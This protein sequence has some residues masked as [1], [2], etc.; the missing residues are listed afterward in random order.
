MTS[1]THHVSA[2][3]PGSR[4][5]ET[6]RL[7]GAILGGLVAAVLIVTGVAAGQPESRSQVSLQ[8][9]ADAIVA[10]GAPGVVLLTRS[11]NHTV[12]ITS[13]LGEIST[14]T[15]MRV[16]DRFRVASLAKT[17]TATVVL[18]LVGE[19]KLR[20][21]DTVER[22]LPGLV[23]GGDKINIRQLLNHTSGLA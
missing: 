10:G 7:T 17:Y 22:W 9:D 23:P 16:N 18:Q 15:P 19:G 8:K 1:T 5:N 4:R 21:T 14:K 20:L 3:P 13:G 6:I 11:G 12:S 2:K